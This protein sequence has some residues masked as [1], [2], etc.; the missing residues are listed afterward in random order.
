MYR[1]DSRAPGGGGHLCLLL[2]E[3]GQ[4]CQPA[5]GPQQIDHV[6]TLEDHGRKIIKKG[7]VFINLLSLK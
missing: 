3:H 6:E 2:E 1:T 4:V 7:V 5:E